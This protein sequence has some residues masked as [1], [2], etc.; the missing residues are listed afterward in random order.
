MLFR[1]MDDIFAGVKSQLY[2]VKGNRRIISSI[3]GGFGRQKERKSE[4]SWTS[5]SIMLLN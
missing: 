2:S 3:P 4:K 5:A 1:I